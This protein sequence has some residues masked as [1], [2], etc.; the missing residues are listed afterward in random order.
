M[1]VIRVIFSGMA[2]IILAVSDA[3]CHA[4]PGG[5]GWL[6]LAGAAYPHLG[7][8][9][10]GR[11]D[12][13]RRRGH[14]IFMVDGL[15]V[16]AVIAVL[17]LAPVPSAVL[18]TINLF[19]W[20]II[21]GSTLIA[22]GSTSMLAGL[23]LAR[24]PDTELLG[25]TASV[26]A[27]PEWLA[28]AILVGYFLIVARVI[29][30]LV[31]E[32]R[33][34]QAELLAAAD[35]AA[36]ARSLAERALLAVLP[37]SVAQVLAEKGEVAPVTLDNATLLLIELDWGDAATP[38]ISDLA[39]ALLVCDTILMRHGFELIKTFGRRAIALNRADNGPDAAVAA[40]REIGNYFAD[41]RVL[42]GAADA[43]RTVR[44]TMHHGPVT[45]GLV[46]SE[47][48]NPDL[49][50]ETINALMALATTT[51][52]QPGELVISVAA[53]RK[54]RGSTGL[55]LHPGDGRTPPCYLM[56]TETAP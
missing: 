11:F 27:A 7:H 26:C 13:R 38:S 53:Q 8:L 40:A 20:M 47:R 37:P 32:L 17:Q 19:N 15:F 25:G 55:T 51:Q 45:L 21:G 14:L 1:Y 16:G 12:V 22:L 9:L 49:V 50:G 35:T 31:E 29:H 54:L 23:A 41:H 48:L 24:P 28:G 18:V 10:L 36:D 44:M 34:Q 52:S 4:S 5:H 6:L 46:Q 39:D 2:L 3:V 42:V 43:H 30:Q 33:Q 56:K